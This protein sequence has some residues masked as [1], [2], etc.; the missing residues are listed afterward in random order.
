M[1][2]RTPLTPGSISP[3]PRGAR[4]AS[5]A[6]STSASRRRRRTPARGAGRRRPSRRCG[7]PAGS[8]RRRWQAVGEA[9]APGVTTDELDRVGARVPVRPRRLPVDARLPRLPEVAVHL[10]S[11]RSS[12]TASR[13]RRCSRTATSSTSTSPRTSAACTATPTRPSCVGDVDEESRLLVERTREALTRGDQGGRPGRQINVDRPGH[14]VVRQALRLR[15]GPRLH[16]PRHRHV[17][18][19]RPVR[20]ALRRPARR[21]R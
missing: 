21:R 12:A 3:A 18:P 19:L 1:T 14:R 4:R 13:T 11:T 8:P 10:A 6:P 7:S 17:V 2:A 15:R 20:P 5:R 16:R 9:V